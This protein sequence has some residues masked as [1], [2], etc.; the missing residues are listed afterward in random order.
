MHQCG[1]LPPIHLTY[2]LMIMNFYRSPIAFISAIACA[3][4][5]NINCAGAD[6][7][8]DFMFEPRAGTYVGG[9]A[10]FQL[11][12][13]ITSS[14]IIGTSD[15]LE[16][17]FDES[18][19]YSAVIG[20][21][22][23]NFRIEFEANFFETD[24][25][26]VEFLNFPINIDGDLSYLTFMGNVFYDI[27]LGS[28]DF[29]FYIGGG[30][31]LAIIRSDAQL[32]STLINST[33]VNGITTTT[34]IDSV[35]DTFSTFAYQAMAGLSYRVADNVTL[36]GGYRFRGFTES[37]NSSDLSGLIFRENFINA[38]ELGLRFDF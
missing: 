28:N 8:D 33:T 20:S 17:S 7:F 21:Y 4:L 36:T 26:D 3:A 38:F 35:D 11:E 10:M 22:I 16:F 23:S 5:L 31:G 27:P 29:N 15:E 14:D 18:V 37:G 2:F 9:S 32:D 30:I 24:Y 12:Y 34:A 13:D 25:S 19:A 1:G 6:D